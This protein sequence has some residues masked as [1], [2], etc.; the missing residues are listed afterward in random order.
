MLTDVNAG[1]SD[2]CVPS[3]MASG[4]SPMSQV[5]S[6]R[7]IRQLDHQTPTVALARATMNARI[8]SSLAQIG[9]HREAEAVPGYAGRRKLCWRFWGS[10]QWFVAPQIKLLAIPKG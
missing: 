6:I 9:S 2:S 3:A 1:I 8:P 10:R 5:R 4:S 7:F